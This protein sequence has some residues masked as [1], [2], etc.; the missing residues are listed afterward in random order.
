MRRLPGQLVLAAVTA[1][2]LV[3]CGGDDDEATATPASSPAATGTSVRTATVPSTATLTM[4][5]SSTPSQTSTASAPPDPAA[6]LA[7]LNGL[8]CTGQW[9]NIT[10]GT[11]G[12]FSV[13]IEAGGSGGLMSFE[14]GGPVFGAEGGVFE[15][16]FRLE[17]S[18][19]VIDAAS[20]F[21]GQVSARIALDGS[22]A[23][24][25]LEAPPAL[26]ATARVTATE[27]SF[28]ENV[29]HVALTT[30]YGDGRAPGS[31]VI[32]AACAPAR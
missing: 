22:S 9:R 23:E 15:A 24:A 6:A 12:A 8:G 4:T 18:E 19:M 13:R 28:V 10:L 30:D 7:A 20:E 25:T 27:Y 21:L 5:P 2:V 26:G 3:A 11:S 16:P 14:I 29:L 17:G 1:A 32:D 31:S